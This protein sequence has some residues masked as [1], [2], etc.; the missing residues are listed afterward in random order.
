MKPFSTFYAILVSAI[1]IGT[2]AGQNAAKQTKVIDPAN[3]DLSVRPCDNFYQYANGEWLKNNP[4]PPQYSQW[5]SFNILAEHN[6][7]VLHTILEDAANNKTAPAGSNER[8]IGDFYSAGMDSAAIE[9]LGWQ[10]VA[11]DL[12]R[13]AAIKDMNGVQLELSKQHSMNIN[14]V[15]GFGSEQDPKNSTQVIGE[16]HQSGLGL[17][18]RDY[19]FAGDDRSKTIREEYVKFMTAM[20]KLVGDDDATAAAAANSVM[21]FETRLAG[22]SRKLV[23]LRD[24]EKNYNKMTQEQLAELAPAV[25]WKRFFVDV[26]WTNPGSVDVGQPEFFKEINAMMKTVPLADWKN[27]LRWR[28]ISTSAG[29][30]SSPFVEESFRFYG[31]ILT[32]AKEMQPRWKRVRQVIDRSMGEAL[33]EVYVA[34]EFPPEAKARALDLVKNIKE[35]LREHIAAITWMDDTTKEAAVKKLNAIRVKIG[36]P[37]K[38]RDYSK[39]VIDRKSY[40]EDIRRS[41]N[42]AVDRAIYKI[43]KPVDKS[44]WQMSPQTVNAYYD[45]S[46]NEIVFPAG[47]L[48]PPFF[49]FKADDA[50]NYGGIGAVI[51]HEITHGFDD[52]GSKFDAEG[53]LKM[54]WTPDT[55]KMFDERTQVLAKQFDG[56]I[57]ID[58]LHIHGEAT[59]GENIADL[60]GLAISFT[61]LENTLKGKPRELIDGFTPEQ[62]FFLS[63]AQV[64]RRNV[65]PEMLRTQIKT[66]VHSPAEFRVNGPLP[67]LQAFYDAFGCG[68]DSKMYIPP[69]KRARIWNLR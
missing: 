55:R 66:D 53:N 34:K 25:E 58:T 63:F 61:A 43:G 7:D 21:A 62:R 35:A 59:L 48:Q 37:D 38:W 9:A 65:R 50:V 13:I 69:E 18:E 30:L 12:N 47:I 20:F 16:I 17:P 31:T 1:L 44:E 23:D 54:W 36:Y 56:F 2:A 46:M 11:A 49:D 19:Y 64:W 57:P 42:F 5:G 33:G 41:G 14:A 68:K 39:L 6:S 45:A 52:Q 22:A 67:D 8:K 24:P 4:I 29:A 3:M 28:I 15:F 40:L 27:Y 51:G 60:G 32:G 26:G 10:P